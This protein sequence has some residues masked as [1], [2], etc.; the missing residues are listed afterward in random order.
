ML[1]LQVLSNDELWNGNQLIEKALA[2]ELNIFHGDLNH[3]STHYIENDAGISQDIN[4]FA[5]GQSNRNSII[6]IMNE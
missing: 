1:I 2:G 5:Y 6:G 4:D 3:G